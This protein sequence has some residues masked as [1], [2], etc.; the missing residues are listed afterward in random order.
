MNKYKIASLLVPATLVIVFPKIMVVL[1]LLGL[2]LA[3]TG[4]SSIERILSIAKTPETLPT[5]MSMLMLLLALLPLLTIVYYINADIL[6]YIIYKYNDF[7][8]KV[9]A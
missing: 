6:D 5:E 3:L 4:S 1:F 8:D 9:N 2:T 7:I